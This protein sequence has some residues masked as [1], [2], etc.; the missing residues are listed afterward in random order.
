M[1]ILA[2]IFFVSKPFFPTSFLVVY[3]LPFLQ[4]ATILLLL[5]LRLPPPLLRSCT[6]AL[7]SSPVHSLVR[8]QDHAIAFSTLIEFLKILDCHQCDVNHSVSLLN[9][10]TA[11]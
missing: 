6:S 10:E 11:P 4:I 7:V 9:F 3:L 8:A 1:G 2:L 5:L